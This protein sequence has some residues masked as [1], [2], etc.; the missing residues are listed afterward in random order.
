MHLTIY[1]EPFWGNLQLILLS[2]W[3]DKH[4]WFEFLFFCQSNNRK[5]H[6]NN[7]Q[8]T[9]NKPE[10]LIFIARGQDCTEWKTG[11]LHWKA[12]FSSDLPINN[13]IQDKISKITVHISKYLQVFLFSR[14]GGRSRRLICSAIFRSSLQRGEEKNQTKIPNLVLLKHSVNK[15]TSTFHLLQ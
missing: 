5:I 15:I 1:T 12:Y 3:E 7:P 4:F 14:S 11:L 6:Q 13:F 10:A 2:I 8:K 9:Y